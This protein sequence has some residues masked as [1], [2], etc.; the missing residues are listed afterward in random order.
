MNIL[1][2]IL[3][4]AN[5]LLARVQGRDCCPHG[6][7]KYS[8][9]LKRNNL[10]DVIN[11]HGSF[12]K[13]GHQKGTEGSSGSTKTIRSLRQEVMMLLQEIKMGPLFSVL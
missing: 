7:L 6:V 3:K 9:L 4:I 8:K 5:Q 1:G 10:Q 12:T 2:S 13:A 11:A